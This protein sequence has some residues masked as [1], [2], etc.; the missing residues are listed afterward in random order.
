MS[1]CGVRDISRIF[2]TYSRHLTDWQ[3]A[4]IIFLSFPRKAPILS[5]R[6][7]VR[8]GV[9]PEG[10]RGD[11]V[12]GRTW[13]LPLALATALVSPPLLQGAVE[14]LSAQSRQSVAS[15]VLNVQLEYLA[16]AAPALRNAIG[17][18]YSNQPACDPV[19]VRV[20]VRWEDGTPQAGVSFNMFRYIGDGQFSTP[21]MGTTGSDG[22]AEFANVEGATSLC[23]MRAVSLPVLPP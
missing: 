8:R 19:T 5:F 17:D 1:L 2:A 9:F 18:A 15:Q 23:A 20:L 3:T 6:L 10:E 22:V 14:T 11:T 7:S 13:L 12:Q 21:R 16:T 4:A